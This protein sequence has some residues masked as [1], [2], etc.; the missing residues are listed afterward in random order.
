[1]A[2]KAHTNSGMVL[3]ADMASDLMVPNPVSIREGASVQHAL[4]LLIDKGI[5]GAPLINE[6]GMPVGI[7]SSS[8]ILIHNRERAGAKPAGEDAPHADSD[9]TRARDIM[10]PVIFSVAPDYPARK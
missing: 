1:M 8:D 2:T 10:T 5:S 4:A 9:R 3:A 6:D 7:V